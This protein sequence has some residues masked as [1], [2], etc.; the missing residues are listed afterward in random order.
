[1]RK[2]QKETQDAAQKALI[3]A[4]PRLRVFFKKEN[5][6]DTELIYDELECS[7]KYKD[8]TEIARGGMK[9]IYSVYDQH[10][11]RIIAMAKLHDVTPEKMFEPFLR[12]ARLTAKL[13]HPNII[14]IHEI[15]LNEF[16]R[17]FFTMDLKNGENL[18]SQLKKKQ[19]SLAEL[20]VIF[21]KVCD[22]IS[23]AHSRGV[24]H[25]DLKPDNI[26]V[27]E[28]GEVIVCDWG[29]G[30]IIDDQSFSKDPISDSDILNNMT[31]HGK[32]KGTPGFM[33]PEQTGLTNF[34]NGTWTDIYSLGVSLYVILCGDIPFQG[35]IKTLL[36]NTA[37]G[38]FK[39]PSAITLVPPRL[40]AICL[41]AMNN[42]PK[43]RYA[44]VDALKND[45]E[46]Y[47]DGYLTSI[48]DA[49]LLKAL[50]LL[51]KR[52]KKIT[53]IF[54]SAIFLLIL[55][56]SIFIKNI[57]IAKNK[58]EQATIAARVSEHKALDLADRY[59]SEKIKSQRRGKT[60][61]PQF[62][63]KSVKAWNQSE[64]DSAESNINMA[65]ILNPKN[66]QAI[67]IKAGL[68]VSQFQFTNAL[69]FLQQQGFN[70]SSLKGHGII[71]KYYKIAH[72]HLNQEESLT[73]N[74]KLEIIRNLYTEYYSNHSIIL[75]G[76][77]Y[78]FF[79]KNSPLKLRLKY[80]Q[81]FLEIFNPKLTALNFNYN[82]E[83][84]YLDISNNKEMVW[85][86]CLRNFPA[87][88]INI[89]HTKLSDVSSFT[90]MPLLEVD[91]SHSAL[92]EV[93]FEY[94]SKIHTL[95]I[96]NTTVNQLTNIPR[97]LTKLNI[98]H[99]SVQYLSPLNKLNLLEELVIHKGQFSKE[100]LESVPKKVKIIQN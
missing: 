26:Q 28:F 84:T 77:S 93:G 25:L 92:T 37:N 64:I 90:G 73:D 5:I 100:A 38:Q 91:A 75:D 94:L 56:T 52:N 23:Y 67:E 35:E 20:L 31:L 47:Q 78:S 70:D 15:G 71:E 6:P 60:S 7:S 68:L 11:D 74:I 16:S 49:T 65:L 61:A 87:T 3:N 55:S 1:M 79:K 9:T 48:E 13:D 41:K 99:T 83:Q 57:N 81:K 69:S 46:A 33:A 72:T 22:A 53:S 96:S 24:I 66:N 17:P 58:A 89:S 59:R 51:I 85:A 27:G 86:K 19:S 12:E 21:V 36:K 42:D 54:L 40:E 80:T 43:N 32:I 62:I 50:T 29:L 63:Y 4:D 8:F 18:G 10:A 97:R 14:K 88:R 98:R 34:D 44:S 45:I 30:K 39:K 2:G 76:F 82:P 95:D